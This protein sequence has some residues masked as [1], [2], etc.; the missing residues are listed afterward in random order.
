[1]GSSIKSEIEVPFSC[2]P[3]FRLPFESGVLYGI[4]EEWYQSPQGRQLIVEID[5]HNAGILDRLFEPGV[6]L[7]CGQAQSDGPL[8]IAS[9]TV[10]KP[11]RG[12]VP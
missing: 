7:D 5:A 6:F 1:M 4:R 9:C 12:S 11:S 10:D 3:S 2:P 8:E